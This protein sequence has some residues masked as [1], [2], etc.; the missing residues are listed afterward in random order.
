[1]AFRVN[2]TIRGL[3]ALVPSKPLHFGEPGQPNQRISEMTVLVMNARQPQIIPNLDRNDSLDLEVCGH[4][5]LL[6][7]P[8]PKEDKLSSFLILDGHQI[9]ISDVDL[10]PD[11]N[12]SLEIDPSFEDWIPMDLVVSD[13]PNPSSARVDP[14]FLALPIPLEIAGRLVLKA[15]TVK[16][17]S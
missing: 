5:P 9:E 7:Y 4:L 14:K 1:M 10:G 12:G 2:L 8:Q 16:A 17:S 3:C 11:S 6:R 13:Q 15:G